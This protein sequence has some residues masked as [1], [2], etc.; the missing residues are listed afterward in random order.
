M[1]EPIRASMLIGLLCTTAAVVQGT[2]LGP[3]VP[4]SSGA[5]GEQN[6]PA[7]TQ[8]TPRLDNDQV[9]VVVATLQAHTRSTA[10]TAHGTNRVLIHL[11]DGAMTREQGGTTKAA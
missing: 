7:P 3:M 4:G 2:S 8:I 10:P 1:R 5:N 11:D 9:R 6:P